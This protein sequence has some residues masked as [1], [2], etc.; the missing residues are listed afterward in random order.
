MKIVD[1]HAIIVENPTT[2]G[3][4]REQVV[5]ASKENNSSSYGSFIEHTRSSTRYMNAMS[6]IRGN[7]SFLQSSE[8]ELRSGDFTLVFR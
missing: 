4:F 3:K 5:V 6:H 2:N 1:K 8:I 7:S